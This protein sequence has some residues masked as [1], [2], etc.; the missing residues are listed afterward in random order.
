MNEDTE[1]L[2]EQLTR[3]RENLERKI[4]ERQTKSLAFIQKERNANIITKLTSL[5]YEF[6]ALQESVTANSYKGQG[7]IEDVKLLIED[8]LLT[9]KSDI[10]NLADNFNLFI[11]QQAKHRERERETL[12]L[13]DK[14]LRNF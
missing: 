4:L 8:D 3:A 14:A 9:I 7:T 6:K 10:Q 13:L 2:D 11:T 5:Q 1:L 12:D